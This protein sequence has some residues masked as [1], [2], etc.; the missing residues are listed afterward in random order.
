V[1]LPSFSTVFAAGHPTTALTEEIEATAARRGS[2]SAD[3][4]AIS[5]T[6]QELSTIAGGWGQIDPI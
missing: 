6:L 2:S 4:Q 1:N 5:L 3:K